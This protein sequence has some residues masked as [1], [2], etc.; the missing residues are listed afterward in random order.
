MISTGTSGGT[1]GVAGW[2]LS[3]GEIIIRGHFCKIGGN[4]RLKEKGKTEREREKNGEIGEAYRACARVVPEH[5]TVT[6]V[7]LESYYSDYGV[8]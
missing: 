4:T 8:I 2:A 7:R 6:T 1:G 5:E 3:P